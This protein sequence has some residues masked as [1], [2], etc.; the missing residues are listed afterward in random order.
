MASD[1]SG[2]IVE[3]E[4][5]RQPGSAQGRRAVSDRPGTVPNARGGPGARGV[6]G[7]EAKLALTADQVGAQTSEVDAAASGI[8]TTEA[9]GS[10]TRPN[11]IAVAFGLL[12]VFLV[13]AGLVLDHR[14]LQ[15]QHDADA[16]VNLSR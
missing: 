5:P 8:D 13:I 1:V 4:R 3:L 12:I 6:A 11:I 7:L 14:Q 10:I 16:T 15:C 9:P 2:R